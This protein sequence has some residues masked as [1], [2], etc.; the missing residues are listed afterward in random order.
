M[1]CW[2]VDQVNLQGHASI[3]EPHW[4]RDCPHLRCPQGN[5]IKSRTTGLI[6]LDRCCT[7][8]GTKQLVQNCL[9][10][11]IDGASN[12]K[13][14]LNYIDVILFAP[15]LENDTH[16]LRVVTTSGQAQKQKQRDNKSTHSKE[17]SNTIQQNTQGKRWRRKIPEQE[18]A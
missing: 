11:P 8:C 2:C 12:D 10:K 6:P 9:T 4:V 3:A 15:G 13:V 17:G 14:E 16:S 7:R 5:V 18:G 1:E